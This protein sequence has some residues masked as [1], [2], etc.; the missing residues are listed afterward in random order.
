MDHS[1]VNAKKPG[2]LDLGKFRIAPNSGE[3]LGSRKL[4]TVVPVTKPSKEKFF[5]TSTEDDCSMDVYL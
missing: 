4:V 5:Q 2:S 3:T 1:N